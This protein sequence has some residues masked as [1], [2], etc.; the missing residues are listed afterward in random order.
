MVF[1]TVATVL[2]QFGCQA[3][4][5]VDSVAKFNRDRKE[6]SNWA[7]GSD[8]L[9]SEAEKLPY[10]LASATGFLGHP[11]HSFVANHIHPFEAVQRS[12]GTREGLVAL[13]I[14]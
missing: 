5:R 4:R 6:A 13:S 2:D 1:R 10:D 9:G 12:P 3:T 7:D 14:R 11:S 8:T